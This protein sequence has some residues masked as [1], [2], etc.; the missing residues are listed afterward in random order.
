MSMN[1]KSLISE[2]A[3]YSDIIYIHQEINEPIEECIELINSF[4]I[5]AGIVFSSKK[6]Y[7]E[8]K[9]PKGVFNLMVLSIDKPGESGQ[10]FQEKSYNIIDK[11]NSLPNRSNYSLCVDGGVNL[12]NINK[13][14]AESVT[15]ASAI[16]KS[17]NSIKDIL[18]LQARVEKDHVQSR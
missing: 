3:K 16:I 13:I 8:I 17:D 5:K 14:N 18:K 4:G 6:N 10:E 7:E 15:S 12:D 1:P 9:L 11:I 2:T